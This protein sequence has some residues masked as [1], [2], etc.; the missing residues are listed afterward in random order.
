M[1]KHPGDGVGVEVTPPSICGPH[2]CKARQPVCT[3][4]FN[5]SFTQLTFTKAS[6]SHHFRDA[7]GAA[8]HTDNISCISGGL[9]T[10]LR[11]VCDQK[12]NQERDPK[13]PEGSSKTALG[14]GHWGQGLK[15]G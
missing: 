6:W 14:R 1:E 15:E 4:A 5:P 10:T 8:V 13:P 9:D 2:V 12:Q 3:H 11:Q 7:G